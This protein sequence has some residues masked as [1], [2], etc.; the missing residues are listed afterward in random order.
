MKAKFTEKEG[1]Y[2]L[3]EATDNGLSVI[4]LCRKYGISTT[5]YYKWRKRYQGMSP[6]EIKHLKA[7]EA[8]N[9]KLERVVAS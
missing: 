6:A 5:T 7:L 8:E 9:L 1:V 4:A 2:I 3:K